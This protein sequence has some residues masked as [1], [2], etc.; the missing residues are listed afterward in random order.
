[1]PHDP[2]KA[3]YLHIPF[4]VK[5]CDYCDFTSFSIP[6]DHKEIDEY[7]EQLVIQIRR[8]AKEAELAHLETVYIGGG[9]PSY[10]GQSRLSSLLYALSLSMRLEPDV[11]CTMEA[12]PESITPE[13][14]R[15]VYALGVN[16]LSIGVQSF[17]DEVLKILGRAHDSSKADEAIRY[18]LERFDNV[19]IDLMCGVPSQTLESF[20][21]SVYHAI[22][23]G[24]AHVSIYPLTIEKGTPFAKAVRRGKLPYP[25]D[26]VQASCMERAAE[27]LCKAGF[28]RYEVASY[29]KPG[30]ECR[31]NISYWTGKP[32]LGLGTGAT[33]MTQNA[34]RRMREK[35]GYIADDLDAAQ[36]CAEDLMLGMRM[37][38]GVSVG[39]VRESSEL[40]PD[41]PSVFMK[42]CRLGLVSLISP[43]HGIIAQAKSDTLGAMDADMVDANG[44]PV[45]V[46]ICAD[47][48]S[49]DDRFAPTQL[50]W[51]C[52]NELYGRIFEL[53]P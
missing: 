20:E 33:T 16:R 17:D 51:L 31:H 42:L 10:I 39:M 38:K 49:D 26:D 14:I 3:L 19:S 22:E 2:Y 21:H 48:A 18:A 53:A 34:E 44:N 23:A 15:D 1:M 43:E 11:E 6:R 7:I 28:R 8:K 5:K 29:A 25:D 30:F 12:N 52:G 4:C 47:N 37:S 41:A 27:L 9:T 46:A 40:L 45:D 24:V 36:M 32:Y 13:L 50:G 35:D